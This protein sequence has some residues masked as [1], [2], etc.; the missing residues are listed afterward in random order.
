[1]TA[2]FDRGFFGFSV[3]FIIFLF[4]TCAMP[5]LDGLSTSQSSNVA[6]KFDFSKFTT[7]SDIER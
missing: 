5:K 2:R 4:S 1:M 3:I 7:K 6:S